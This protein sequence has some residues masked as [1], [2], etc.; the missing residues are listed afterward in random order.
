MYKMANIDNSALIQHACSVESQT[1][2]APALVAFVH[3]RVFDQQGNPI[4]A[5]SELATDEIV[6]VTSD[7]FLALHISDNQTINI[8]PD[9]LTSIA[10]ALAVK[11]E[12]LDVSRPYRVGAIRG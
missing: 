4:T 6:R 10:C 12:K 9:T 5:G 3:G 7:G 11:S 1:T 8:Q 2:H